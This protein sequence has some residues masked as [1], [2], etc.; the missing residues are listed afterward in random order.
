M[1]HF[2]ARVLSNEDLGGP[3]RRLE[4][5]W[6]AEPPLPGSFFTLR[7]SPRH[8]PLLRRPLAFSA[9]APGSAEALYQVRGPATR[10]LADLAPG[11]ALDVLGP[12]GKP[13]APPPEGATPLLAAGGVGLGP[14]LFFAARLAEAA[15]LGGA[16]GDATTPSTPRG[17][18]LVAGFRSA[19]AIPRGVLP[20]GPRAGGF[21]L[22]TEDGSAGGRGTV[23]DGLEAEL[24]ALGDLVPGGGA[25]AGGSAASGAGGGAQPRPRAKVYACGPAAMLAA[26]A[27]W[28]RERGLEA[29]LS[30][31]Q[32]MACGVGACMGCALPR[33]GGGFLRACADGPVFGRD[34]IDWAAE[35]AR[36]ASARRPAVG[37]AARPAAPAGA[38][39]P[40]APAEGGRP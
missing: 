40:E 21:R 17:P 20:E 24:R 25:S 10:M 13:F 27:A 26:V 29:E 16:A 15:A 30:A 7:V 22:L 32:W 11:A 2:S 4:L 12:L 37:D 28:A 6:E 18:R 33:P 31:E 3:W 38:A 34:E 8:D 23:L 39:S 5:A 36:A 1:R 35:A 14:M 9:A 19:A